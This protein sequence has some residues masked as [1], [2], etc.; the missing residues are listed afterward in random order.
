MENDEIDNF[1]HVNPIDYQQNV[2]VLIIILQASTEMMYFWIQ[3]EYLT[4]NNT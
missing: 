4:K 3:S 2:N 1:L